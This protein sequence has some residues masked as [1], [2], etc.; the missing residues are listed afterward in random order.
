MR[1]SARMVNN[2]KGDSERANQETS[3]SGSES[4]AAR[5]AQA[6]RNGDPSRSPRNR[7]AKKTASPNESAPSGPAT[8]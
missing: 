1:I 2:R 8:A 4:A 6:R 3:A 7:A 5:G